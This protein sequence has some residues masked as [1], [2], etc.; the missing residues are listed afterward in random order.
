MPYRGWL[1]DDYEALLANT[2]LALKSMKEKG[3][4]PLETYFIATGN[5]LSEFPKLPFP[6][7]CDG[8][9]LTALICSRFG[10]D[11]LKGLDNA[12]LRNLAGPEDDLPF[13]NGK[14]TPFGIDSDAKFQRHEPKP[15]VKPA[16]QEPDDKREP[17]EGW[18]KAEP[19]R[20]AEPSQADSGPPA[21]DD[22]PF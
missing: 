15:A 2:K 19:G 14:R 12:G 17:P 8:I 18:D 9:I 16:A 3:F 22:I 21:D 10:P 20:K 7:A 6:S 1:K 4:T 11:K 5:S 13:I